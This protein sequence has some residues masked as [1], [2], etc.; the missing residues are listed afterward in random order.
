MYKVFVFD[1]MHASFLGVARSFLNVWLNSKNHNR[2]FY[3]GK[4][5]GIINERLRAYSVPKKFSRTVRSLDDLKFWKASE[6][7]TW[8]SISLC[9]LQG[10]LPDDFRDHFQLFVHSMLILSSDHVLESQIPEANQMLLDFVKGVADLYGPEFCSFNCH[11]LTHASSCVRNWGPLY[12]YSAFQFENFNGILLNLFQ[13][14][15]N[16]CMEISNRMNEILALTEFAFAL[17]ATEATDFF[18]SLA[19]NKKFRQNIVKGGNVIFFGD[20]KR[21]F[22]SRSEKIILEREGVVVSSI[23]CFN[24]CFVNR[25]FYTSQDNRSKKQC[26]FV[27]EV[28]GDYFVIRQLFLAGTIPLCFASRL[29]VSN[30]DQLNILYK[31]IRISK[32][33]VPLKICN[34]HSKFLVNR[35]DNGTIEII[36]RILNNALVGE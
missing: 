25:N 2:E 30:L 21:K 20:S 7:S 35:S 15:N 27:V 3:L 36:V 18:F 26:D 12:Q 6:W 4:Y 16:V 10:V 14:S 19:G 13:G 5:V 1:Y 24:S 8:L 11:S 9:V 28:N 17:P 32:E 34:F 33:L 22:L 31:V 23:C 29:S